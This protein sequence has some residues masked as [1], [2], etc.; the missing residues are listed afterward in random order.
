MWINFET[1][2]YDTPYFIKIYA[3]GVNAISAEPAVENMGS[4][5]HRQMRHGTA[6]AN[7]LPATSLQDY[8]VVPG[9]RWLDGIANGDG[10]VR[11]FVATPL[12]SG[13]SIEAQI[14]GLDATAGIQIEVTPYKAPTPKQF[15]GH[16]MQVFVKGLTGATTTFNV[17]HLETIS[18]FKLRI[19]ET[20][21]M[22]TRDMRL[23]FSGKQL[24]GESYLHILRKEQCLHNDRREDVPRL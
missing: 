4:R 16:L 14:T 5:L 1:T 8:V 13:H 2:H 23:I 3:G 24:E 15:P 6:S 22:S 7:S 21:G 9:Q 11:Q 18:N 19:H 20:Q 17:T 10:T 12:G